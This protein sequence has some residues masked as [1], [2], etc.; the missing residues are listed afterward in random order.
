MT[1]ISDSDNIQIY[2][3]NIEYMVFNF[4][5]EKNLTAHFCLKSRINRA[6]TW[7]ISL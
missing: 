1:L 2:I 7:L 6:H 5:K 4:F 3:H